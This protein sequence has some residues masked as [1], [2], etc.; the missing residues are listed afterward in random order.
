M[1]K[2]YAIS[3]RNDWIVKQ[4]DMVICYIT[5]NFGETAKFVKKAHKDGGIIYNLENLQKNIDF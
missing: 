5:H 2:K 4:S 1:P 3:Y